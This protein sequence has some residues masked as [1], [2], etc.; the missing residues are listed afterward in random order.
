MPYHVNAEWDAEAGVWVARSDDVPGLVAEAATIEGLLDD[1][2][3]IVP[4]LLELNAVPHPARIEVR[5]TAD[6]NE[7]IEA[8]V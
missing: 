8:A 1:L 5:L 7:A 4:D 2:R 6:R 3:A